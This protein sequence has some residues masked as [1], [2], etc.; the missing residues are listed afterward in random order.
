[1]NLAQ[2]ATLLTEYRGQYSDFDDLMNVP[3]R[4]FSSMEDLDF[5]LSS[6]A[7]YIILDPRHTLPVD[8]LFIPRDSKRLLVGFHGAENRA[9]CDFP[10]FQFAQSFQRR[11]DSLLFVFDSTLLQGDKINIGWLAGN[12]DTP[13]AELVSDAVRRAGEALNVE[14]TVL[15]GHSAG[16]Y[17]AI[18]VGS[19]VPNSRAISVNGQSVVERYSQWTV[20]NLL[21]FAFPECGTQE[22]MSEQYKARLDLRVALRD[23][24]PSSS[25]TY[26]GNRL[27][28]ATF[29]KFPHFPLLAEAF[30]LDESGGHTDHGD[31]FVVSEWGSAGDPGHALPGTIMPF[32]QLALG[33]TPSMNLPCSVDPCWRQER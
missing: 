23:R 21:R 5:D 14:Q 25:F 15:A 16:G 1:M 27:D 22:E 7:R 4:R 28:P 31:A 3:I 33:E 26:F 19:K 32:I 20:N 6:P 29:S 24:L 2:G 12:K 11:S 8:L 18:L 10:K 17:S 30:G 13:L 9:A